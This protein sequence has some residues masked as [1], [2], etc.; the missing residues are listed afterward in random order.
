[1]NAITTV[2]RNLEWLAKRMAELERE[3]A[4]SPQPEY[5]RG[6]LHAMKALLATF[7]GERTKDRIL[8]KVRKNWPANPSYRS[9]RP[10]R[11]SLWLRQRCRMYDD[12]V[13]DRA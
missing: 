12:P 9:T 1:V 7:F 8:Q 11:E 13:Q 6:Q 4:D 2:N 3:H 10:K 5:R